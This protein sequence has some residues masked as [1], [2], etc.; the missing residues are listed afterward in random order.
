MTE[1]K[2]FTCDRDFLISPIE[3]WFKHDTIMNAKTLL[4]VMNDLHEE[5]ESRKAYQRTL[6]DKIR[7]LKDRIKV[8]E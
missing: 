1:N 4:E 2:R 7:R 8:L 5:N 3:D 6:E